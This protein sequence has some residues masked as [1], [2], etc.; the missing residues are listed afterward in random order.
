[1]LEY[2]K[3]INSDG[4][5]DMFSSDLF[6][7]MLLDLDPVEYCN[8][9]LGIV[10]RTSAK[11]QRKLDELKGYMQEMLQNGVKPSTLLEIILTENIAELRVKLKHIEAIQAEAEQN[12]EMTKQEAMAAEEE[13]KRQFQIFQNTLDK[14][15]INAEWDRKDQN[16]MIKGEYDI[17]SFTKSQDN[18]VD[19]IPDGTEI[20]DRIMERISKEK[21]KMADNDTKVFMQAR[22]L[23]QRERERIS[24]EKIEDKKARV[25]MKNKVSGEK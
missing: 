23:E 2:S 13:R 3:I 24:K 18:D 21:Q 14:E 9:M 16:T 15:L 22:E 19:G 6:D 12:M 10:V 20:Q 25:A 1:M 17:V 8:A 11:D 4:T 5:K 7:S